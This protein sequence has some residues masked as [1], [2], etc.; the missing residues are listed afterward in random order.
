[1]NELFTGP[2]AFYIWASYAAGAAVFAWNL[3]APAL[4]R[5]EV[6]RRLRSATTVES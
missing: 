6:M 4:K 1:M 2:Y 5:R 3:L